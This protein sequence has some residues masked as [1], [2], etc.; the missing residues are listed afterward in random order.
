MSNPSE[1]MFGWLLR[2]YPSSFR[3]KF[4]DEAVQLFRDR[5]RDEAGFFR[6]ARLYGDLLL[7]AFHGLPQAWRTARAATI[8]P[9]LVANGD[10]TPSFGM[11]EEQPL[12]PS[13][14]LM[15]STIS[16]VVLMAFGALLGHPGQL[17]NISGNGKLSPVE[18]V[19]ERLNNPSSA[20]SENEAATTVA[21]AGTS[22]AQSSAQTAPETTSHDSLAR[23]DGAERDQVIQAVAADLIA[24]YPDHE[25][26]EQA[27]GMLL[28][29]EKRGD[30]NAIVDGPG[31]AAQL[32]E[33]V[34]HSTRD[35]HL[36]VE[37][38]RDSI[39]DG[40]GKASAAA[41][42]QYR[43]ALLQQDC[44]IEGVR[45]V[46]KTVG[47]LKLNSFPDRE[48]CG[49]RILAAIDSIHSSKAIIFDLRDNTGGFPDMVAGVAARLFDRPVPWYNPRST[50][51]AGMLSPAAGRSLDKQRIYIVTSSRTLSAAEQFTYNLKMLKRATV[52]GETTGGAAHLG[53][54]HRIDDHFGMG[55]PAG[56]IAN[57]YGVPD[58][59]GTGVAPDVKVR[60][61]DALA[62]AEK[63]AAGPGGK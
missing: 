20:G 40:E 49:P 34:R 14:I 41:L 61:A 12:R 39:P 50:P 31:L 9:S 23:V 46:S 42:E 17:L 11:L 60:A 62:T 45:M 59:D 36:V 6:K 44:T 24:H 56:G 53:V 5:L 30:Y 8:T 48:I 22:P 43:A 21:A 55:I 63:L 16:C 27:S 29:H 7:D 37:Y 52:V 33:D 51:S 15:G 54:F 13:S 26:A 47:Y 38:S 28:T 3:E 35:P 57:P 19:M 4:R 32:T 58:W 2:L 1:R 25:K 18:S 10:G